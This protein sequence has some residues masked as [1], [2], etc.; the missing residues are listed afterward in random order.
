MASASSRRAELTAKHSEIS[1]VISVACS[2]TGSKNLLKPDA[3]SWALS[4]DATRDM[5][6]S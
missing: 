4:A 5:A 3:M 1:P 2:G 6:S